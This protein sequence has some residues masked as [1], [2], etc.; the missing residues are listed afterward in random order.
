MLQWLMKTSDRIY[1]LKSRGWGLNMY[2]DRK[3]GG[4]K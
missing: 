3:G 2:T 4:G 1:A